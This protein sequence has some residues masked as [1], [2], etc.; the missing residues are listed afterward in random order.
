MPAFRFASALSTDSSS[1]VALERCAAILLDDLGGPPDVAFLFASA[2]H[3]H[4]FEGL[5]SRVRRATGARHLAGCSTAAVL[6]GER[7]VEDRAGL[8]LLGWRGGN[9][10]IAATAL[11]PRRTEDGFE[12]RPA[13]RAEREEGVLLFA[14]PY[15]FPMQPYLR[16]VAEDLGGASVAGG[17]ASGG[18][19]PGLHALWL[20]DATIDRGAIAVTLGGDLDVRT[21]VSQGCRPIGEPLVV[22]AAKGNAIQKLGGR[23]AVRTLFEI[24]EALEERDR[25]L[26]RRGPHVGLAIDPTKSRF[27]PS[28]LLVRNIVGLL[29]KTDAVAIGDDSLRPGMTV[30][31]MLRDAAS[32][33]DELERILGERRQEWGEAG[34]REAG[35]LLFTCGGRGSNL[36]RTMNHD[37]RAVQSHLGPDL[38]LAGFFANGEVGTVAGRPFLHGFTASLVYLRERAGA[39][40]VDG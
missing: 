24:L 13:L 9:S 37:V 38:P 34:A 2:H 30:Q 8:S 18:S 11:E 17:L 27:A 21:V 10:R 29:P 4:D 28:D 6:G 5:G 14:D 15:S 12:I 20:D 22:T 33:S 31:F 40:R 23:P 26:F 32:A 36:F 16:H 3:A 35:A 1:R 7:E 25:E 19:G 39:G